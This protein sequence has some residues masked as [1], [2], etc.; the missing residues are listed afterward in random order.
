MK[1]KQFDIK[2]DNAQGVFNTG[3]S[4]TGTVLLSLDQP[5]KIKAIRIVFVGAAKAY[6]QRRR[7]KTNVS[8]RGDENY[9]YTTVKLFDPGSDSGRDHPAGN[10]AYPF[11]LQLADTL[12]SSFEGTRGYVRYSC[13]ATI[14]RPL[15][16]DYNVKRAFTVIRH[17]DL[18]NFPSAQ[19]PVSDQATGEVYGCCGEA[20]EVD[21]HLDLN[22]T[23][24]VPGEPIMYTIAVNNRSSQT[25]NET[26]LILNQMTTYTGISNALFSNQN[27]KLHPK[28]RKIYLLYS[29]DCNFKPNS[30]KQ[31]Q[32]A[33]IVPSLPPTGLDGCNIIDIKYNIELRVICTHVI[34]IVKDIVIGTI[35]FQD[36]SIRF[37]SGA[38]ATPTAPVVPQPES[39]STE[40]LPTYEEVLT[41]PPSYAECMY[42]RTT[43]M[44]NTDDNNTSGDVNW[45]PAYPY[46]NWAAF[47]P[48][49]F[50]DQPPDTVNAE[51]SHEVDNDND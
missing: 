6:W 32:K 8:Y 39:K 29:R 14:E 35:P 25:V 41:P 46:Y 44:D 26:H 37:T 49:T 3:T 17:F 42:G 51:Q 7:G 43:I 31:I 28:T 18:N 22:K 23:G 16:F 36:S 30:S 40:G 21:I 12:P 33:I 50:G 13:K 45:A 11:S 15:A 5:L 27:P 2:F 1:F 34:S 19:I 20:G 10:H 47:S 24:F 4:V 48:Q 38:Q 9:F